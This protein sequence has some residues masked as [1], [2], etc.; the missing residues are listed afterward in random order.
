MQSP[1]ILAVIRVEMFAPVFQV[2]TGQQT[3][4]SR[5][6]KLDTRPTAKLTEEVIAYYFHSHFR[7]CLVVQEHRVFPDDS[8]QFSE[9]LGG[10]FGVGNKGRIGHALLHGH[11]LLRGLH[12]LPMGA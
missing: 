12:W 3:L 6:Y 2:I 10:S 11:A 7:L 4:K 5:G 1:A 8:T 9:R